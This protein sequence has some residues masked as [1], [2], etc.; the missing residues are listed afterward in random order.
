MI[1]IYIIVKNCKKIKV[2]H[3]T[4]ILWC[5]IVSAVKEVHIFIKMMIKIKIAKKREVSK[6]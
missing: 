2:G 1:S 4:T 5:L 6:M 3:H